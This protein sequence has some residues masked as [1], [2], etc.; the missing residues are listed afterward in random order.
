MTILTLIL[1]MVL[2][3]GMIALVEMVRRYRTEDQEEETSLAQVL[4]LSPEK[5]HDHTKSH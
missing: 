3:W 2:A 1:L 4:T 5:K